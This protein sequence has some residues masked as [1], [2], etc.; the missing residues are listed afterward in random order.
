MTSIFRIAINALP[1]KD[2]ETP[3]QARNLKPFMPQTVRFGHA[4]GKFDLGIDAPGQ[5]RNSERIYEDDDP[6]KSKHIGPGLPI[7]A[8]QGNEDSEA[9]LRYEHHAVLRMQAKREGLYKNNVPVKEEDDLSGAS[10]NYKKWRTE[11]IEKALA[12][13]ADAPA[14]DHSSIMTNRDHAEKALAYDIPVGISHISDHD[15]VLFRKVADW[16]LLDGL[17]EDISS[18][19]YLEYFKLGT[20]AGRSIQSWA[21]TAD[22]SM[23]STIINKRTWG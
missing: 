20:L 15:M 4:A 8:A 18:S 7:D 13:N 5:S 2:W 12:E 1:E 3:L 11:K 22:G 14:T 21:D 16:R 19:Q 6:Y 23:P 17:S 10:D 9:E